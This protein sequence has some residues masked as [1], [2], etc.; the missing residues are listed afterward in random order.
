MIGQCLHAISTETGLFF[1]LLTAGL[2]GGFTHCA[3]MC[4]P[5]VL[6]Q[7]EQGAQVCEPVLGRL[8][9]AAL[10]P[11]HLGRMTT[12]VGLALVSSAFFNAALFYAPVKVIASALLLSL[13]AVIF[14]SGIWPTA[15]SLFPWISQIRLPVPRALIDRLSGLLLKRG[16][17]GGRYLLGVLLGFMPCGLVIAALMA[18]TTASHPLMA[19]MAMAAFAIGTIPALLITAAGLP[20]ITARWPVVARPFTMAMMTLSALTLFAMAGKLIL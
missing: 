7:A 8:R 2:L 16:T 3:G 13:A 12:Y 18:A 19:G 17:A 10:L 11:Y 1:S 15:A 14:L 9:R 20:F 5:F 4:G 6:A